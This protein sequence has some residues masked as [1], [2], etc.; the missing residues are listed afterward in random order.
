MQYKTVSE[1]K[2]EKREKEKDLRSCG[3]PMGETEHKLPALGLQ[4]GQLSSFPGKRLWAQ[5]NF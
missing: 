4:D 2:S 3:V 1:S 5:G